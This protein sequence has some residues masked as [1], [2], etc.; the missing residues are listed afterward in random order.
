MERNVLVQ[1]K[2]AHRG[3]R[4]CNLPAH[5]FQFQFGPSDSAPFFPLTHRLP[6]CEVLRPVVRSLQG[7]GPDLGAAGHHVR[8]LRRRQDRKGGRRFTLTGTWEY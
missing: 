2:V 7:H 5:D 4:S 8:A 1:C 3:R 6:L